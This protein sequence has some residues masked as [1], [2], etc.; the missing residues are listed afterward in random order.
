MTPNLKSLLNLWPYVLVSAGLIAAIIVGAITRRKL[1]RKIA[2]LDEKY[3]AREHE[4]IFKEH[5]RTEALIQQA[6]DGAK[7]EGLLYDARKEV[8]YAMKQA[9][10]LRGI[11]VRVHPYGRAIINDPAKLEAWLQTLKKPKGKKK[12]TKKQK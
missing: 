4:F 2:D 7:R 11:L 1:R 12:R 10:V 8:T 9:D 5:G 3:Y 6:K